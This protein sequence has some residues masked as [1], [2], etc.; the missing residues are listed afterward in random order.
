LYGDEG[1]R[2]YEAAH[3]FLTEA[4]DRGSAEACRM[5]GEMYHE[6]IGRAAD[7]DKAMDYFFRANEIDPIEVEYQFLCILIDEYNEQHGIEVLKMTRKEIE[8]KY[9]GKGHYAVSGYHN[10]SINECGWTCQVVS[11]GIKQGWYNP[12]EVF[13][14]EDGKEIIITD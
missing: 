6:G 3:R 11:C 5:L 2:D 9:K 14:T 1:D 13:V 12:T 4:A 7:L 8:E 10:C